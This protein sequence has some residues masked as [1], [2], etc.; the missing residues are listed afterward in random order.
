LENRQTAH[1]A[2]I[3][4][5]PLKDGPPESALFDQIGKVA[6]IGWSRGNHTYMVASTSSVVSD[7][8]KLF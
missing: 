8:M 1:L 2:V 5:S 3:D 7:L 6:T 4:R